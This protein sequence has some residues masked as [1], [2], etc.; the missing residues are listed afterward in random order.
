MFGG[1]EGA[2]LDPCY[3]QACD[4]IHNLNLTAFSQMK[5]AAADVLYQLMLTQ[6]SI[7]D[8]SSIKPGGRTAGAATATE[9]RGH[10]AIR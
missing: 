6:N 8:G 3:H 9:F 7:T 4:T 5:D 2:P 10:T 1:T